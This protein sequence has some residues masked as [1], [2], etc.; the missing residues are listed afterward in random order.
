MRTI[1]VDDPHS[2]GANRRR[3]KFTFGPE[4]TIPSGVEAAVH[5]SGQRIGVARGIDTLS[6]RGKPLRVW[7]VQ[8][9]NYDVASG[10]NL[11]IALRGILPRA[12]RLTGRG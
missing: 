6:P 8:L 9:T 5:L 4:K 11:T 12:L 7:E 1:Y 3:H 2:L 10:S